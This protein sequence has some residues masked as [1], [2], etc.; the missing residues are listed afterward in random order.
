MKSVYKFYE[1]VFIKLLTCTFI[2]DKMAMYKKYVLVYWKYYSK[3]ESEMI[4]EI[5]YNVDF[6]FLVIHNKQYFSD[7]KRKES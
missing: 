2:S 4:L 1:K 5:N 7:C 3:M 6:L